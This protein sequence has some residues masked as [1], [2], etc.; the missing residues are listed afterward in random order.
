[1]CSKGPNDCSHFKSSEL[2]KHW[3]A[4]LHLSILHI[5][6]R[7]L[8]IQGCLLPATQLTSELSPW[9]LVAM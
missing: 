9:T 2:H 4:M 8:R 3:F 7:L 1:M 6:Y 5:T